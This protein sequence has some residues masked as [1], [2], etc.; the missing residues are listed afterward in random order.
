M[1][2]GRPRK[3]EGGD[4]NASDKG[5]SSGAN[6]GF[7]AKLWAAADK[8]RGHMDAAKYKKVVLGL[9]FLKYISN[10]FREHHDRLKEE[11]YT[12]PQDRDE[13][14]AENVFW[15]PK[16]ARWSML[17]GRAKSPEIGNL[18]DGAM[19]AIEKENPQL[20][21]VL[22]KDYGR[23]SLDKRRLGELVDLVGTIGLGDETSRSKDVL[24]RVYEY[25]LGK[26]A[27][28]EGKRGGEFWT[29]QSVVRVLVEM[30]EPFGGR[31]YDPCCGLWRYVRL[32]GE[33]RR[34]ARR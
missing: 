4:G 12:D 31:V 18:V 34:G 10:T 26:F 25:F 21:E 28:A 20:E 16:E 13:Y 5:N 6:L 30:S 17:Q 15:V 22:P 24:G 11:E 2:R 1:A 9:I 27:A 33:V 32:F 19:D 29:P 3:R 23:A 14:L 7:E 8:L